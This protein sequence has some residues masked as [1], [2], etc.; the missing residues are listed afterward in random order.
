MQVSGH[1]PETGTMAR[2]FAA[3]FFFLI[4]IFLRIIP[5][6]QGNA[7]TVSA[8]RPKPCRRYENSKNQAGALGPMLPAVIPRE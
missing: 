6:F 1:F 5:N 2:F 3:Q 7:E 8:Q 4:K